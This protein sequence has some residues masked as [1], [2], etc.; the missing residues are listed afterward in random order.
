MKE[1]SPSIEK[2]GIVTGL[3]TSLALIAYF[4]LMKAIGLVQILELRFFNIIIVAVGV[5]YGIRKLKREL[6]EDEF[7]LK[8]IMQGFYISAV[9]II[10]FALFIS[11]YLSYFDLSLLKY[12]RQKINVGWSITG[13]TIFLTIFME[14]MASAV[15]ITFAAM[16]YFKREGNETVKS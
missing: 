7:Y 5:C 2:I 6:H 3:F 4:M 9:A 15:I 1:T 12:I 11:V 13:L 10:S 8:G 14:G 16:Q